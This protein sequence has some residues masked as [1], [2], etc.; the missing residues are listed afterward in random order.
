MALI[1]ITIDPETD[2]DHCP[3]VFVEEE[4]G[5]GHI[6]E[7]ELVSDTAV[8]RMCSAAFE[9]VWGRSIPHAEYRS[10]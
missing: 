4:A 5:D 6:L 7:D 1:F 2:S 8:A 3:A 9:A 10:T